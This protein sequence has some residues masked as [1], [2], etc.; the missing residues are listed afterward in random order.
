MH[1]SRVVSCL[2]AGVLVSVAPAQEPKSPADSH[3]RL[4]YFAGDWDVAIRYKLSND[5]EGEG[6]AVCQ[7]KWILD[8]N[9]LR[10]EYRSKFMGQPLTI[11]QL[12]GYD[13]L[14]K[15]YVEFQLHAQGKQTHTLHNEGSFSD[16][17]KV[18]TL[19]GDST[20]A[21]TGK[22]VKLRTVTT[23]TDPEHYTLEWFVTEGGGKEERKVVLMHTRKK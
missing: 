8:D 2:L 19:V 3:K 14:N 21:A 1:G 11:W 13:T 15:K 23:M 10:Q 22:P 18:L 6:K 4:E 5:K 17:G 7:T 9:F 16:D 20:D 12:L